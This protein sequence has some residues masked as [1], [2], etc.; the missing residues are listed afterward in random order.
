MDEG[1]TRF[2]LDLFELPYEQ[3]Y[4]AD[5]R[6]GALRDRFDVLV[7]P[8]A[9]WDDMLRG[10]H[11]DQAPPEYAGGASPAGLF[12]LHQ[13][14]LRGGTLV[15][16]DSAAELPLT[17]FALPVR[18]VTARLARNDFF[19]PGTLLR[20][21]VDPAH[22]LGYGMPED[23]TAFFAHSP[24]FQVG[25]EASRLERQ[26]GIEPK[27]PAGVT[28]AASWAAEKD[29]L[30]SGWVLGGKHIAGKAAVV[31]AAVGDGRV[32]LLGLRAQ[33]RGQPHGTFKLLLNALY[34]GGASAE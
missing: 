16:L 2:V 7:L 20:L 21:R 12:H 13:F 10:L 27:A 11:P 3:V 33:H 15:T 26:R 1:W 5:L 19:V 22:P 17:L 34:R 29:L 30:R 32:V 23:A 25:R 9:D 14:A 24:A 8:D 18:D 31:D 4:D 6:A 28:V